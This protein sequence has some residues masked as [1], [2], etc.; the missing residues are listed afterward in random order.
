MCKERLRL[1]FL[2][3]TWEEA[4]ESSRRGEETTVEVGELSTNGGTII[5]RN[6]KTVY[7]VKGMERERA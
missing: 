4:K 2:E 1:R 5:C 6:C 7:C 3:E